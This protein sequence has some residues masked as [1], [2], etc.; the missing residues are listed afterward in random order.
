MAN[1]S[2]TSSLLQDFQ[3]AALYQNW[4]A[5]IAILVLSSLAILLKITWQ[6]SYPKG[7][8]KVVREWPILGAW[9]L[10]KDRKTF[11]LEAANKSAT[12]NFS[13]YFGKHQI[14]GVKGH[15][16]RKTFFESKELDMN[17]G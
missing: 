13:T 8:P 11:F 5:S 15:E 6:P 3:P 1:L 10:Y 2:T 17:E 16:G 14:V 4:P 12:G 9:R 7:A